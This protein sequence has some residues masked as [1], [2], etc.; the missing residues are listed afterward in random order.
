M[1]PSQRLR[2]VWPRSSRENG[3]VLV[4]FPSRLLLTGTVLGAL[5]ASSASA[6]TIPDRVAD[7]PGAPVGVPGLTAAGTSHS[8]GS[9]PTPV[10]TGPP[11]TGAQ[12]AGLAIA[13]AR[14][15]AVELIAEDAGVATVAEVLRPEAERL[16]A[17][18]P[19]VEL[20]GVEQ[21]G[22]QRPNAQPPAVQ[23]PTVQQP[24]AP[25]P[26]VEQPRAER[27]EAQRP[28][29]QPVPPVSAPAPVEL[30]EQELNQLRADARKACAAGQLHGEVC[31][32]AA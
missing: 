11:I 2:S 21:P 29:A 10:T 8:P 4:Q 30:N 15:R 19:E 18:L 32:R 25:Q 27:P 3:G 1:R 20:P 12:I 23:Q 9:A 17:Q 24:A 14:D 22:V 28:D 13:P 16:E 6:L 26:R 7:T 31:R 5:A